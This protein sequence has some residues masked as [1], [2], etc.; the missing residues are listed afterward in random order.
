MNNEEKQKEFLE[1]L[2]PI[3]QKLSNYARALTRNTEDARD[4]ASETIMC[5][6]ENFE[7][8]KDINAFAPYVFKIASRIFKRNIWRRRFWGYFDSTQAEN[9]ID[10][11]SNP[12]TLI[13]IK[14]LYEYLAKLPEKQ[15]EALVLFEITGLSLEEIT[16]VQGGTISGVKSRLKRGRETLKAL[17]NSRTD[18]NNI[19]TNNKDNDIVILKQFQT[20]ID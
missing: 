15:K 3:R 20:Q 16:E 6:Y 7:N 19:V 12:D 5:A 8:L 13:D 4:L 17:L 11:N 10:N 1:I 14:I 9:I 2:N 18:N